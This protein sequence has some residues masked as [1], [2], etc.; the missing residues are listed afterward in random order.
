MI[1]S[2]KLDVL[3]F[4]NSCGPNTMPEN[5]YDSITSIRKN[6]GKDAKY[7]FHISTDNPKIKELTETLF[8]VDQDLI[9]KFIYFDGVP[10]NTWAKQFNDFVDDCLD[11]AN[12][13]LVSHDDVLVK[14]PDFFNK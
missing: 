3:I 13:V 5:F 2:Q 14:T 9:Y 11:D 1:D 7:K 10:P 6:I 8:A 12:Y 4:M